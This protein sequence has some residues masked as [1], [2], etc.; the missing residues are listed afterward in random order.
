MPLAA[1]C[2]QEC[3]TPQH[4]FVADGRDVV[5]ELPSWDLKKFPYLKHFRQKSKAVNPQ[6]TI[7]E[8]R[9]A[10]AA[11]AAAKAGKAQPLGVS[12]AAPSAPDAQE[13]VPSAPAKKLSAMTPE[14]LDNVTVGTAIAIAKKHGV[15][16][17]ADGERVDIL[18]AAMGAEDK[19]AASSSEMFD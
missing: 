15:D 8:G 6:P 7:D 16:L 10:V 5:F 18:I 14:E 12:E 17:D 4:G 1:K 3:T 19:A 9:T 2:T 13:E 11:K